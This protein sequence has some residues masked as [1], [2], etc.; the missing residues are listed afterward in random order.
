MKLMAIFDGMAGGISRY[1]YVT[2]K[3]MQWFV[4]N[5]MSE[6]D[7]L[8]KIPIELQYS[9]AIHPSRLSALESLLQAGHSIALGRQKFIPEEVYKAVSHIAAT[10]HGALYPWLED[11][12]SKQAVPRWSEADFEEAAAEGIDLKEQAR[13]ILS[14]I[15]NSIQIKLIRSGNASAPSGDYE[16]LL[17]AMAGDV[18]K[19]HSLQIAHSLCGEHLGRSRDIG[20]LF[21]LSLVL[22]AP[23]AHVL[24]VLIAGLGKFA[25]VVFPGLYHETLRLKRSYSFGAASWQLA[26]N[27][28]ARL[29]EISVMILAGAL[30]QVFLHFGLPALAGLSFAIACGAIFTGTELRRLAKSRQVYRALS[31]SGKISLSSKTAW[32]KLYYGPIWWVHGL[33]IVLSVIC[34]IAV[35]IMFTV[36]LNN[37]WLL[38]LIAILPILFFEFLLLSWRLTLSWRFKTRVK[39][40][41]ANSIIS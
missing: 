37:G 14:H 3:P 41:L 15:G 17:R 33:S 40:M 2:K 35:F 22:F 18:Q 7:D 30:V 11:L 27:I 12:A 39:A 24:E 29:P 5:H 19:V 9:I 38:S 36:Q 10:H 23:V 34:T 1:F 28:K 25:A 20:I 26:D 32:L 8:K 21:A 16:A 31:E 6:L 4:L 13:I